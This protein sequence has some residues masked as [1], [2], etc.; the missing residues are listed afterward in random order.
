MSDDA[1]IAVEPMRPGDW[2]RVAEI[3]AEG[4]RTGDST[5]ETEVP[6]YEDWDRHHLDDHRLVAREGD[7]ILGWAAL[8]RVSGREAYRGVAEC[9]VY[10]GE[11]AR[12]R[13]VGELL[14]DALAASADAGGIW[15]LEAIV[16][17][18][19]DASV[20]MLERCG[21]RRVGVR[22]R[23]AKRDGQ[24]RDVILVERRGPVD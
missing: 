8:A 9:S 1:S 18:G 23:L 19:N 6:S 13:G 7:E 11:D 14:L 5:F 4:I 12:G 21:F 15:T 17:T 22:E 16:L 20:A 10:V 2:G 24:W 3:Y